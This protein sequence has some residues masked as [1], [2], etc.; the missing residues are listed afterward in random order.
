MFS[1]SKMI[2]KEFN[3]NLSARM[4]QQQVKPHKTLDG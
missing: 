3:V 2:K 4:I 1:V